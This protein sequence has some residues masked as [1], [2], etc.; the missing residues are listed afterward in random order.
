VT[1]TGGEQ[2][3]Q[4][5]LHEMAGCKSNVLPVRFWKGDKI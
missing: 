4:A 5:V 1:N 3:V 2:R